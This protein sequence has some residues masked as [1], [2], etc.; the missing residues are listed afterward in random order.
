MILSRIF[1][2]ECILL[3]LESEDKDELFEEMTQALVSANLGLDR[4]QVLSALHERE[5]KMSTGIMHGIAVPHGTCASVKGCIGALGISRSGIDYES[6]D[7]S[8]VHLVFMVLCGENEDDLHLKVLKDLASALQ[9]PEFSK[10]IEEKKSA[11]DVYDFLCGFD[12][13]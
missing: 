13:N 12:K 4:N 7:G 8:P 3:N 10:N 9:N 6:L 5:S 1:S 2:K 11:Q